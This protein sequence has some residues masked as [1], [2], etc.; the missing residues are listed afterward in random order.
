VTANLSSPNPTPN[1]GAGHRKPL[2]GIRRQEYMLKRRVWRFGRKND[3]RQMSTCLICGASR[4]TWEGPLG[5]RVCDD[6][7]DELNRKKYEGDMRK[8]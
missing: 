3:W 1:R 2:L 6:C 8:G 5:D 4:P 7:I